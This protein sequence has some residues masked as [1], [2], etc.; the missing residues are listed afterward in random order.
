MGH[1]YSQGGEFVDS[2]Q[3]LHPWS[4]K[5]VQRS[6]CFSFDYIKDMYVHIFSNVKDPY[7]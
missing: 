4:S 5:G 3:G 7:I 6:D 2:A 1:R